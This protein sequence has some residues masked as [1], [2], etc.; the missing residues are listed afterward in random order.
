MMMHMRLMDLYHC[1]KKTIIYTVLILLF[2]GLKLY[3]VDGFINL[4]Y[5]IARI[6]KN[7]YTFVPINSLVANNTELYKTIKEYFIRYQFDKNMIIIVVKKVVVFFPL[8]IFLYLEN[9]IN[10]NSRINT[11]MN[12]VY[13]GFIAVLAEVLQFILQIDPN[14]I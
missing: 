12:I 2:C 8:G 14:I 6:L 3:T 4:G 10:F 11:M 1:R 9:N 7:D 5:T 13:I